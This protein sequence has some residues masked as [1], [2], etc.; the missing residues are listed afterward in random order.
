MRRNPPAQR[1]SRSPGAN[2]LRHHCF[3]IKNHRPAPLRNF[4]EE[5]GHALLP[6]PRPLEYVLRSECFCRMNTGL[7]AARLILE[8]HQFCQGSE[9]RI[10]TA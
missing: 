3:S 8:A 7:G 6:R 1:V 10:V 2:E 4:F 9:I 5:P